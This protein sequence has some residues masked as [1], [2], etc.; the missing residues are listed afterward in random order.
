MQTIFNVCAIVP[1]SGTDG[2]LVTT[3]NADTSCHSA[4][5]RDVYDEYTVVS[6][7]YFVSTRHYV[8]SVA[9]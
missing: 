9:S 6:R 1:L 7:T 8:L 2:I 5:L 3:R 4:E